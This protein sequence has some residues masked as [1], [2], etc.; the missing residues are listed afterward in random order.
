[1]KTRDY[2]F[3]FLFNVK[4]ITKLCETFVKKLTRLFYYLYTPHISLS[5][6]L[7]QVFFLNKTYKY[8]Q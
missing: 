7:K 2:D 1:M 5:I 3:V 6:Q 4:N 8:K